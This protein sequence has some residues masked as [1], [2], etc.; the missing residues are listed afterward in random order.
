MSRNNRDLEELRERI[1][2]KEKEFQFLLYGQ[3]S[4]GISAIL[5]LTRLNNEVKNNTEEM[6][7]DIGGINKVVEGLDNK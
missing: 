2:P 6:K 5:E 3:L 1:Y 7:G 4:T